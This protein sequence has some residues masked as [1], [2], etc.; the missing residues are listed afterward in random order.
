MVLICFNVSFCNSHLD[1]LTE[2][3][4]DL[5]LCLSIQHSLAS[6]CIL[7]LYVAIAKVE[8]CT[9]PVL[10][11]WGSEQTSFTW[12][13]WEWQICQ[14]TGILCSF[15]PSVYSSIFKS[16]AL[17]Q[18][19]FNSYIRVFVTVVAPKSP[20]CFVLWF[21]YSDFQPLKAKHHSVPL[22][23]LLSWFMWWCFADLV[24]KLP[25]WLACWHGEMVAATNWCHENRRSSGA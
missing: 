1:S 18:K 23:E 24:G 6:W 19:E 17:L 22:S 4:D 11:V 10:I 20:C 14:L 9:S 12:R 21:C 16:S 2:G 7:M 5:S 13:V 15:S 8:M 3:K 25:S